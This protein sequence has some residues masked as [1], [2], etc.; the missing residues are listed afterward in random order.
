MIKLT[1]LTAILLSTISLAQTPAYV[2][3]NGL[4][5]WWPF[6]GN[7]N[8]ESIN[9]N[10]GVLN[11]A[12]LTN[13]RFGIA[14]KA[15]YFNGNSI[16]I[17]LTQTMVSMPSRT[18]SL[19]FN[20]TTNQSGGRLFETT[21][22][23][24][25]IGCYNSTNFDCWF[26]KSDQAYNF[27]GESFLNHNEWYNLVFVCDSLTQQ[28][29]LYLNGNLINSGTPVVNAGNPTDYINHYLKIGMGNANEAFTGTIDD[30]GIWDRA[31][32]I[33]EIK[34]LYNA[35]VGPINLSGGNDITVCQGDSITLTAT[36]AVN[37]IWTPYLFLPEVTAVN[38]QPFLLNISTNFYVEGF[39]SLGCVGTDVVSVTVINP[40]IT[41]QTQTALDAY[42]WPV[43][44]LTYL[45]SGTYMS[46]LVSAT[47][48]DSLILLYLTLEHTGINESSTSSLSIS[49]N[50]TA[51]DFTIAGLELYNNIS[52]MRVSDVNGKLVKELDPTASKFTLGTVKSGVYFLT[53]TVGNKQEVIKIMKE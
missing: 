24:W 19:W 5:G 20:S 13:D 38:G 49:P 27:V 46:T 21:N 51:S 43:N 9:G 45:N 37:Y 23:S 50:P 1:F 26:Q 18:I 44:N 14:N 25:G 8:D 6:N 35:Y 34:N 33:C 4:V 3:Y 40:I 22:Y 47:G 12:S 48:C 30:V 28:K 41:S 39:D 17:P 32:T 31:L 15:Y 42:T 2:P 52:T 10:N 16:N 36:G 29:K 7:T 53:I 11:G